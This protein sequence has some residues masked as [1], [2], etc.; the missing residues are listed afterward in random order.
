[1]ATPHAETPNP[2]SLV[3]QAEAE[4]ALGGR[5]LPGYE[6]RSRD[7]AEVRCIYDDLRNGRSASVGVWKGTEAHS[8]YEL[9]REMYGRG[10]TVEEIR[11]LGD[12]AFAVKG[13]EGWVNVLRGDVYLSIQIINQ[14]PTAEQ[15]L[16]GEE[17]RGRTMALARAAAGRL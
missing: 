6:W 5:A 12:R 3:T 14:T 7:S 15:S 8:V 13:D 2:C 9:R 17:L 4:T 16:R 10:A 11:G 1:V